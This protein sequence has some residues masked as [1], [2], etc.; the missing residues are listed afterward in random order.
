MLGLILFILVSVICG[1][2]VLFV[3]TRLVKAGVD[4]DN[5]FL[6]S[7]AAIVLVA[8]LVAA[9]SSTYKECGSIWYCPTQETSK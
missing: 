2:I 5:A 4:S 9:A 8:G 3:K 6:C 1:M 7:M